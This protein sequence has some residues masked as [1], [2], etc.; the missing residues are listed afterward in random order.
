LGKI[1]FKKQSYSRDFFIG[2]EEFLYNDAAQL[3]YDNQAQ[4]VIVT[5][6]SAWTLYQYSNYQVC[7]DQNSN[8]QVCMDQY[9]NYQICMDQYSNYQV[10]STYDMDREK[11]HIK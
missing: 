2:G 1:F 5:G 8:Y 4:S 7:M 11:Q 6:C 10:G 3:N 9:S